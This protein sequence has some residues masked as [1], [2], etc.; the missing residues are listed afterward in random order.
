MS[1]REL[2]LRTLMLMEKRQAFSNIALS[3]ALAETGTG[4]GAEA[5]LATELLYGVLRWM[6]AIDYIIDRYSRYPVAKLTLPIRNILR[7]AVYQVY[8]LSRIPSYAAVD[9]A[10]RAAK[11]YGHRGT[12]G[13]VNAVLRRLPPDMDDNEW[14]DRQAE[15]VA[16]LSTR[17]SHPAWMVERWISAYGFEGALSICRANNEHPPLTLRTNVLRTA[18]DK[19]RCSLA[20]KG[21]HVA[22]GR[23]F[24]EALNL[25]EGIGLWSTPE[26]AEGLFQPQDEA[27]MCVAH[28]LSPLPGQSVLDLCSAPGGKSTHVAEMMADTGHVLSVDINAARLGLV[29]ANAVRLGI[30]II[31]T[32]QLDAR[33]FTR[34]V[35]DLFDAVMVDAPCT[36][37]GVLRRKP[38]IKWRLVPEKLHEL[39]ELQTAILSEAARAVRPGGTL[40]Y[41]TC[42]IEPEEG[43]EII[44]D[45]LRTNAAYGLVDLSER[46]PSCLHMDLSPT[47][48]NRQPTTAS[49]LEERRS[50]PAGILRLLPGEHGTDGFF[51][52]AMRRSDNYGR[53]S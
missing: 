40:V 18:P 12:V 51:L 47:T 17:Q 10:V 42:S 37:T 6:G 45:F 26:Y 48:N 5:A 29:R 20:E 35:S 44:D 32:L 2:A 15:P 43:I 14:P 9:E 8:F 1:G 50:I 25:A 30:G 49:A 39:P 31:D 7:L 46:L 23:L 4:E 53:Q 28:A 11:R 38:E 52:A 24:P 21:Y 19:L 16:Y 13:L 22:D 3:R 36:G 34:H 41:S 33:E 27:S